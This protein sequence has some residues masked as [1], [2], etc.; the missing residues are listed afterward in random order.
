[1]KPDENNPALHDIKEMCPLST[2]MHKIY[3]SR[4]SGQ[5]LRVFSIAASSIIPI[6][7]VFMWLKLG[8][9][10]NSSDIREEKL[11]VL[12]I[13][14]CQVLQLE[15]FEKKKLSKEARFISLSSGARLRL[16]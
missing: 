1:M 2:F 5:L 7:C 11:V 8:R 4:S 12:F 13:G 9:T 3:I 14:C 15:T 10:T 6:G 16:P